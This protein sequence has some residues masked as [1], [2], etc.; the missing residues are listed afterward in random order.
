MKNIVIIGS[1]GQDGRIA[2]DLALKEGDKVLGISRQ[3]SVDITCQEEVFKLCK[4]E[5]I[6]EIYY[7]AAC[8][9][10]S[11]TPLRESSDVLKESH[12]INVQGLLHWC[13]GIKKYRPQARLFYA[14]SSLIYEGT[15][16]SI[17]DEGTPFCPGS[18]YG[19]TKLNGLLLCRY[20]RTQGV[21]ASSGILYNHESVYR[22]ECFLSTKIIKAVLNIKAGNQD[23]LNLGDLDAQVDW[24][25][26]WD[27]V[28][29][30]RMIMRLPQA[31]D[32][33][34]A[35]GQKHSVRDFVQIA[36]NHVGLDWRQ[37]V[38]ETPGI[39]SRQRKV[40]VGN[41]RKLRQATGWHPTVDFPGMIKLLLQAHGENF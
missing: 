16:T 32:F 8:H 27:Y 4:S 6:D 9:Q 15:D 1:N 35:S 30:M 17:Q 7:L 2:V 37:Y 20:Y 12:L 41:A 3:G 34:I 18:I 29:A 38:H 22:Q 24:G 40:L 11:Q 39:L 19:I 10:S 33:I 28:K 23:R 21:F 14:S 13:E 25:Y 36:F 5:A 26:A 31:D